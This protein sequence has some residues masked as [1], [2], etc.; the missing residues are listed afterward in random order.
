M[1]AQQY[2]TRIL[3]GILLGSALLLLLNLFVDPLD[4]Y[5]VYKKPGINAIK[6]K[7]SSYERIAKPMQIE[8]NQPQWLVF[9]SSR[10][11]RGIAVTGFDI[12]TPE[13]KRFNAGLS[14]SNMTLVNELLRHSLAVAEVK[15]VAIGLDFFMFN[16]YTQ[17]H[18]PFHLAARNETFAAGNELRADNVIE[19]L[20]SPQM[21]SASV[22][23]LRHQ[24]EKY[25]KYLESGQAI[26]QRAIENYLD[27]GYLEPFV[28]FENDHMEKLWTPCADNRFSTHSARF[29]TLATLRDTLALAAQH[30][31][32]IV[33]FIPPTHA[34]LM[35]ALSAIGLWDAQ[36]QWKQD[37]LAVVV[38]AQQQY[39]D[40]DI[41]LW[42][43]TGYNAYTTEE[44]PPQKG[45][46]M[47]WWLESS[48]FRDTLGARLMQTIYS[49]QPDTNTAAYPALRLTR[50]NITA[51]LRE[52]T[53]EQQRYRAAHQAQYDE[54]K[55]RADKWLQQRAQHGI[56]CSA[57]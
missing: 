42:D 17:E 11:L 47:Q 54:I 1:K 51:H 23:T 19:T 57:L 34:R 26:N 55:Q 46:A 13:S 36:Q 28:R 12:A 27:S 18:Y 4:I 53:L 9:G 49:T 14:G 44:L 10:V 25:N 56:D 20:F 3:L 8:H 40:A 16:A 31:V 29:D 50:E 38:A 45:L 5:R 52:Q 22:Y 24:Q 7:Y 6:P 2:T 32:R 21:A 43:M 41:A 37:V 39:P 35:E 15:D 48:H 33:L 30:H